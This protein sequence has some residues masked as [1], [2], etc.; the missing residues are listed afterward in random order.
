[1]SVMMLE[2]YGTSCAQISGRALERQRHAHLFRLGPL[3]LWQKLVGHGELQ[4]VSIVALQQPSC[5]RAV[6]HAWRGAIGRRG[7]M[8]LGARGA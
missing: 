2:I 5:S 7:R 4:H 1:M 3:L 8:P 6:L